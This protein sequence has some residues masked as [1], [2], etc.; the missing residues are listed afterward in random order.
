MRVRLNVVEPWD[1]AA[2]PAPPIEGDGKSLGRRETFIECEPGT[3]VGKVVLDRILISPTH[4]AST[5]D[6]M[7]EG[8]VNLNCTGYSKGLQAL[9]F[10]ADGEI[11]FK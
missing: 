8:P 7:R 11:V 10:V 6:E 5:L 9:R 2:D 4:E 3:H 1:L